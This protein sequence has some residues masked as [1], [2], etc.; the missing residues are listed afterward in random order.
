MPTSKTSTSCSEHR[1]SPRWIVM[2]VMA[3]PVYTEAAISDCLAQW[4]ANVL[5]VNQGVDDDFRGHLEQIAE[6][7]P[8]LFLWSH[9]PPLPSLAATWNRALAFTWTCGAEATLVVNNDVR[10][11]PNTLS[12]L[13][14][15]FEL[16]DARLVTGVGVGPKQFEPGQLV[17]SDGSKGGPDFSCFLISRLCHQRYPFDE[18]FVPAYCE[19]V[20]L[21]RSMLLAGQG[22]RIYSINVPFLH[23]GSVTLKTVDEKTRTRIERQTA[24]VARSYYAQKWGGPV[25]QERYRKPFSEASADD[26]CTTP[27][28][29]AEVT[30]G[31]TDRSV[32]A[33]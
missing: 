13:W 7:Q 15:E 10:L 24:A 22:D 20:D 33:R 12:L 4:D 17:L 26:H 32:E 2:P 9:Q 16:R 8:R 3:H 5:V 27:E 29:Q 31:Q 19:D 30:H 21:H 28:L 6:D 1:R 11:A 25:N 18:H 23:Y 14:D